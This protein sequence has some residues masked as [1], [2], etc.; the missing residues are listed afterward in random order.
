M[1]RHYILV[2]QSV[3]EE[4]DFLKW[5]EW[6]FGAGNKGRI[7]AQHVVGKYFIST[8]FL[9]LNQNFMQAGPA[10]LFETMVFWKDKGVEQ[11]RCATWIEAEAQHERVVTIPLYIDFE[12]QTVKGLD[13]QEYE[14]EVAD[15]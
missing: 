8:A 14:I 15:A 12:Q 13:D 7:V 5:A 9:G 4:P 11:R 6:S 1:I 2:G 3:V 10:H